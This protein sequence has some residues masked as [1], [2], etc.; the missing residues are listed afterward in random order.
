MTCNYP[1]KKIQMKELAR[2]TFTYKFFICGFL[3]CMLISRQSAAW[4]LQHIFFTKDERQVPAKK[5]DLPSHLCTNRTSLHEY[6]SSLQVTSTCIDMA[7]IHPEISV[8]STWPYQHPEISHLPN[9]MTSCEHGWKQWYKLCKKKTQSHNLTPL[10]VN[11]WTRDSF[12]I[13]P[14][15]IT[16][17][18]G[19]LR[20]PNT[21]C[22]VTLDGLLEG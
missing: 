6:S 11:L 16:R 9:S 3:V 13:I 22:E 21:P 12:R 2:S 18:A 17:P 10:C 7:S 20:S 19:T 15:K 14:T 1:N 8:L 5:M 4:I